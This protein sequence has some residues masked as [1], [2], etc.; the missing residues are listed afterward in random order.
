MPADVNNKGRVIAGVAIGAAV[1]YFAIA[2]L[3]L[4]GAYVPMMTPPKP[5]PVVTDVSVS[6]STI[7]LGQSFALRVNAT[8]QGDHAD[9]QIVSV[10]FPNATSTDGIVTVQEENFKQGATFIETG[11]DIGSGYAGVAQK[12]KAQ[13][14]SV[15]IFSSPWQKGESFA[16]TLSV[17]PPQEGRFVFFV[18]A[19]GF[20]H[21]GDQAH[22]PS[23]GTLDHQNEYVS[24]Y[25]VYVMT[26]A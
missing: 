21:N 11:R 12:V 26:K 23:S 25:S 2:V 17:K 6:N 5:E 22:W 4:P 13:Y 16:I 24:V 15:E 9:R 18:K 19:I 1:A 7:E 8:N 3:V 14:P 10:A 20:P